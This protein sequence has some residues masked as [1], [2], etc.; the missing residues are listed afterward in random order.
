MARREG[1]LQ[2]VLRV[3]TGKRYIDSSPSILKELPV[4]ARIKFKI[5]TLTFKAL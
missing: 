5:A 1:L 4:D 2:V 3:V